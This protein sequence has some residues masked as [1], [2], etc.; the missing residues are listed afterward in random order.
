MKRGGNGRERERKRRSEER[1]SRA[2]DQSSNEVRT[3]YKKGVVG[4]KTNKSPGC[5]IEIAKRRIRPSDLIL[6]LYSA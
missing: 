3:A 2:G 4:R 5:F 1:E 6:L